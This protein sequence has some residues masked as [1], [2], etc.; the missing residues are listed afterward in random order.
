MEPW[1][2]LTSKLIGCQLAGCLAA[3]RQLHWCTTRRQQALAYTL[4]WACGALSLQHC[5]KPVSSSSPCFSAAQPQNAQ[6]C[7]MSRLPTTMHWQAVPP[8]LVGV[9]LLALWLIHPLPLQKLA[10]DDAAVAH[11]GLEDEQAVVHHEV[12]QHKA[13]PC[14]S[15]AD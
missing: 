10:A 8:H 3:Y 1:Q 9:D 15:M 13:A 14:I 4:W 7:I 12:A 11:G 5:Q 6:H 2:L